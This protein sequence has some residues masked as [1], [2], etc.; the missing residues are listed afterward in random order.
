MSSG[1][2]RPSF[3]AVAGGTQ[4]LQVVGVICPAARARDDVINREV[5]EREGDLAAVA[6]AFL[7]SEQRM[8]LR[9]I[10]WNFSYIGTLWDIHTVNQIVEQWSF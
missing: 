10:M 5:T 4:Q 9:S 7:E 8:F 3:Q 6:D 2:V 1:W